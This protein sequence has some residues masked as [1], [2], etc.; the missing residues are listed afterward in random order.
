MRA[1]SQAISLRDGQSFHSPFKQRVHYN[2]MALWCPLTPAEVRASLLHGL[3][4]PS[5]KATWGPS[6]HL[7]SLPRS[8]AMWGQGWPGD[9]GFINPKFSPGL[10]NT[11][12]LTHACGVIISGTQRPQLLPSSV[13]KIH[14]C[15]D[16]KASR[17]FI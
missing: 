11:A 7:H 10:E 4:L 13:L 5:T 1:L 9:L 15:V 16:I 14:S 3:A 6:T 12:N 8:A 2:V 17:M